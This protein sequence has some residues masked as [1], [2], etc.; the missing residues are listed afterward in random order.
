MVL[1]PAHFVYEDR[2]C[3]PGQPTEHVFV[4][5]LRLEPQR[6]VRPILHA[7]IVALDENH[8]RAWFLPGRRELLLDLCIHDSSQ[9]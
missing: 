6:D 7:P 2:A 9:A 5:E 3:E 4:I 8:D 1:G